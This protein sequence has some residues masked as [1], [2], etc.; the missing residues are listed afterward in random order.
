MMFGQVSVR[1]R[2]EAGE[3][4]YALFV[5][6]GSIAAT[7]IAGRVGYDVLLVDHEHSPYDFV[8]AAHCMNAA[9]G[10]TAECWVRIPANDQA[11]VKRI[12]DCGADGI[13]CP[14]INTVKDAEQFVAFCRY[15]PRGIRGYAPTIIR[16]TSYG[17]RREEYLQ[18]VAEDLAIMV[19]IETAEAVENAERIAAVDGV[20]IVFIGPMDLSKSLGHPGELTHP[21]VADAIARTEKAVLQ[22]GKVLGTMMMPGQDPRVLIERGNRFLITGADL[23]VLRSGL[24]AQMKDLRAARTAARPAPPR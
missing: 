2:L 15:P 5:E 21:K 18:R 10:T 11:Y 22:S 19:Q 4:Q 3:A 16:A 6:L 12:L 1:K 20:N 23:G 17:Y 14:M 24:E 13:M 7:E 8:N 9:R